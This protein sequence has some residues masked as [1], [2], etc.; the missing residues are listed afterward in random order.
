MIASKSF[1]KERTMECKPSGGCAVSSGASWLEQLLGAPDVLY[2]DCN[3]ES[4]NFGGQAGYECICWIKNGPVN[5][6]GYPYPS[7]ICSAA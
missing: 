2:G 5:P 3:G 6:S 7:T 4:M 1:A